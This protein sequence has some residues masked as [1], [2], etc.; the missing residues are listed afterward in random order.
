MNLM[1]QSINM[2]NQNAQPQAQMGMQANQLGNQYL[3]QAAQNDDFFN[4][5]YYQNAANQYNSAIGSLPQ[6]VDQGSTGALEIA[7][8]IMQI[9]G[10]AAAM[11]MSDSTLKKNIKKIGKFKDHNL[12]EWEWNQ[13]AEKFGL[14][15]KSSGVI[16][17]EIQRVNP[18][19]VFVNDGYLA[20]NYA[21]L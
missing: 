21:A 6:M 18:G 3:G 1:N 7:G 5:G 16:A 17:Q 11:F 12:Y 4:S 10:P 8:D 20:V 2:A 9:A 13:A 19:A 14:K 15:G